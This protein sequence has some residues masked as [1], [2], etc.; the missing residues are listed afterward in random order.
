MIWEQEIAEK[1]AWLKRVLVEAE[2]EHGKE[3]AL[4]IREAFWE[5]RA[6]GLCEVALV[7]ARDEG[8]ERG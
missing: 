6:R 1:D 3:V 7:L 4:L 2:A 5:G 8:G